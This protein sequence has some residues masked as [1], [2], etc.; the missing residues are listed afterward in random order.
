[1][2]VCLRFITW[3]L[4]SKGVRDHLNPAYQKRTCLLGNAPSS[5]LLLNPPSH[6]LT[7][8]LLHRHNWDQG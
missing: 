4:G 6:P 2:D 7:L 5:R 8:L 1:M 3:N